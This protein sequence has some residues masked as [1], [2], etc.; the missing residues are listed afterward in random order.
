MALEVGAL[1][2]A[3]TVAVETPVLQT[4]RTDTGR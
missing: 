4:D 3:V 2:E 1:T